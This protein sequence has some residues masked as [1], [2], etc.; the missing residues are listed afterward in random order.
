ME[1]NENTDFEVQGTQPIE[2]NGSDLGTDPAGDDLAQGVD[3]VEVVKEQEDNN[4]DVVEQPEQEKE[5]NVVMEGLEVLIE[6]QRILANEG[7]S[8]NAHMALTF[9]EKAMS[10]LQACENER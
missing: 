8:T 7:N 1:Q 6:E 10:S 5:P 3:N 9:M 4:V 2:A